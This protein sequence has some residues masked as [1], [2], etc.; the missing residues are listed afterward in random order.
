MSDFAR[1]AVTVLELDIDKCALTHGVG[2]CAASIASGTA[3]AGTA[4]TI[5]LAVG[6]SALDSYYNGM[7]IY[8]IAGTGLG[9]TRT[10]TAYV[11]ATRIAT[12]ATWTATDAT[13]TYRISDRKNACYNTFKTCQSKPSYTLGA[14]ATLKLVTAGAAIPAG[15]QMRPYIKMV[16]FAPTEID[17]DAGLARRAQVSVAVADEPDADTEFDPYL[18]TRTV[19]VAGTLWARF[20][21]RVHNYS[22]RPARIKRAYFTGAWDD[23]Q[24]TTELYTV[25]AIKGPSAQGEVTITLK[26]PLKL[27]DRTKIPTPTSGKLA[28][29]MLSNDLQMSMGAGEGAQYPDAGYVRVGDQVIRYT[30][31]QTA[32]GWNFSGYSLDSWTVLRGTLTGGVDTATF[33]VTSADANISLSGIGL[34]GQSNRYVLL[35]LR[36]LVAGTWEG[37]LFYTTAAHGYTASYYKQ[38]SIPTGLSA[39]GWVTAIWDMHALTAGG[40]DWSQ[41]TITG[42]RLDLVS[43]AA[44]SYEIDW[45][46]YGSVNYFGADVL[47]WP[48]ST[49][50]S[51]FGTT[52]VDAKIGDGVQLCLTYINQRVSTVIQSLLNGSGIADASI[53]V[54]G[55]LAEDDNWLGTRYN[56]TACLVEPEDVDVYLAEIA[57][58]TGGVIWWSPTAQ[59]VR[60]KF[61]GPTSPAAISGLTFTDEANIISGSTKIEPLD[62]LRKTL[63]GVYYELFNAAANRAEAKSYA[64]GELFV[65]TDA[66]SSNEYGDRRADIVYS[67]WFTAANSSALSGWTKR[68]LGTYRDAPLKIDLKIDPKDAAVREGDLYDITTAQI[69]DASGQPQTVRCLILKRTDN[70][71]DI[72]IMA[73]TTNFTRRYGFIA[74]DTTPDYPAN[75]GYA[76]V[77]SNA[78]AM[79]DGTAGFLII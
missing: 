25:D 47:S 13:T 49:Y 39:G 71:G 42:L 1:T 45:I 3:T 38:I 14:P 50:R 23:A 28:V 44:G 68:R 29:A 46:S 26:D 37:N 18:A 75:L 11:G 15:Q 57:V 77:C 21:A 8:T 22:N 70:A 54:A 56:I 62:A 60:Y 30:R 20:F 27:T 64:R 51:Q 61:I 12:V 35:R 76:C 32:V 59:K 79:V 40:E 67:R 17:P 9:Q 16:R 74:P 34:I 5:T 55:N 66:E 7:I 31:K 63:T 41:N 6:S 53:D 33:T 2:T 72:D 43:S 36:Q 10:I 69:V 73:R 58:Q 65:D 24:F 52:A 19:A 48:D 78:G 4:T